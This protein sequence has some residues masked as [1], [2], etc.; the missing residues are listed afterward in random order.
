MYQ[1]I[2][3]HPTATQHSFSVHTAAG[4]LLLGALGAIARSLVR[5]RLRPVP[6]EQPADV[7]YRT[8]RSLRPQ[9]V[10]MLTRCRVQAFCSHAQ[11]VAGGLLLWALADAC[12]HFIH[13]FGS[14]RRAAQLKSAAGSYDKMPPVELLVAYMADPEKRKQF[15]DSMAEVKVK[16]EEVIMRQGTCRTAP[17]CS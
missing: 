9:R 15:V 7:R 14:V 3:R 2:Q 1:H 11:G 6:A 10:H 16:Q 8:T 4:E 5:C 17:I 12:A 13:T